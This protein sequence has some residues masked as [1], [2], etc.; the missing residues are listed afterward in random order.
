MKKT[1]PVLAGAAVALAL[2]VAACGEDVVSADELSAQ[3]KSSLEQSVGAPL[4]SVECEEA[5]AEVGETFTCDGTTPNGDQIK[6]EGEITEVDG[7]TVNF[8][9]EVVSP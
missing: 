2:L 7:D 6:I 9:V 8:N 3:T 4:E 1:R 5:K